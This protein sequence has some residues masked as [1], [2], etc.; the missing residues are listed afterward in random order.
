MGGD[1]LCNDIS[2]R[3]CKKT[4]CP[5]GTSECG[6][7]STLAT[8]G[9]T[10]ATFNQNDWR[11]GTKDGVIQIFEK[12]GGKSVWRGDKAG[13]WKG[14][15]GQWKVACETINNTFDVLVFCRDDNHQCMN[16]AAAATTTAA[17]TTSAASV[18]SAVLTRASG[19]SMLIV[20]GAVIAEV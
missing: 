1:S 11:I 8:G 7:Y 5:G 15:Q 18:S 3:T 9:E 20:L 17:A 12:C 4:F 6:N 16:A 13:T 14:K 2:G 19:L 10:C